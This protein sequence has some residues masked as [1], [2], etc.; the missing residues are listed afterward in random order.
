M[1]PSSRRWAGRP[2]TSRSS[3]SGKGEHDEVRGSVH[4][5]PAQDSAVGVGRRDVL[6]RTGRGR[7]DGSA[8]RRPSGVLREGHGGHARFDAREGAATREPDGAS[9]RRAER[10][11]HGHAAARCRGDGRRQPARWSRRSSGSSRSRT[12]TRS[13][14]PSRAS[15]RWRGS[16][17]T[18]GYRTG[19]RSCDG[20]G[21]TRTDAGGPKLDPET[22]SADRS[23]RAF[24][25]VRGVPPAG[26]E[27]ATR[28]LGN[29]CS[30]H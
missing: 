11:Q 5:V 16:P 3:C 2:P 14:S 19:R 1:R 12:T 7:R 18:S 29:R 17:C 24:P 6:V 4:R 15:S 23:G 30:L 8:A 13:A 21:S 26:I 25:Q 20:R 27:P 9:P 28:G 22:P 10:G